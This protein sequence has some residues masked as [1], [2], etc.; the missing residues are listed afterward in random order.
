MKSVFILT[1]GFLLVGLFCCKKT[2]TNQL[3]QNVIDESKSELSTDVLATDTFITFSTI[4]VPP[5]DYRDSIAPDGR[6]VY[7]TNFIF[8]IVEYAPSFPGDEKAMY[9]FLSKNLKYPESMIDATI[10]G[11]V[12]CRF[13][14]EKDG[15]ISNIQIVRG[16]HELLDNEAVRVI[17]LM[18]KWIPGRQD[19]NVVRVRYI[20]PVQFRLR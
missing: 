12:I 10:Q 18:P 5:P 19:G 11:S 1:C 15:S 2:I 3:T 9:D 13:D 8:E 7:S 4:G 16:I 17:K 20:L 6:K 14:V